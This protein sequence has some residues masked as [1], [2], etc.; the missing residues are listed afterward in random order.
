M[1]FTKMHGAGNDYVYVDLFH[2]TLPLPP[3]KLAMDISRPHY[4]IGSDGLI[5]IEPCEGADARMRIFNKDG[6]EGEMCGNGIRCVAKYLYDSGIAPREQMDIMTGNGLRRVWVNVEG[7]KAV[8]ARVDMGEPCFD[9]Q[10]IPIQ[11]DSNRVTLELC[12][13]TLGFFCLNIGN[14]HAVTFDLFP[15]GEEFARL[16]RMAETHSVF[17]LDANVSFARV[18][19]KEEI[20]AR[21]WERGSGPTLACGSGSTAT[22][23]AARALGLVG[24]RAY[25]D[26]PGGRLLIEYDAKTNHAFMTGDCVKVFTGDWEKQ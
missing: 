2:E 1:R 9:P 6:S 5:L 8:S 19:G 10:K 20:Q 21:I 18:T 4:G 23:I 11:S 7:G 14:P 16:G 3:D 12:G 22:M 17:P 25:I 26:L 13:K 15:E 24:D